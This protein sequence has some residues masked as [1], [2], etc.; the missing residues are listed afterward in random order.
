MFG[1]FKFADF[2]KIGDKM[3]D[4]FFKGYFF[5]AIETYACPVLDII[6]I[7]ALL[8]VA[9][10]LKKLITTIGGKNEEKNTNT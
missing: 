2:K 3:I 6:I 7:I 9:G 5:Q 4:F 1:I 10:L 8:Q